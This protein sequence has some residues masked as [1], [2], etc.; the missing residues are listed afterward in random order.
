M[1][2]KRHTFS[3]ED[4]QLMLNEMTKYTDEQVK[5]VLQKILPDTPEAHNN[6]YRGKVLTDEY[7]LND[8]YEMVEARN[9]HDIFVGDKIIV[10]MGKIPKTNYAG[11]TTTFLV[12]EIESHWNYGDDNKLPLNKGHL[13]LI[14][15]NTL[16]VAKMNNNTQDGA[17]EGSEMNRTIMEEVQGVLENA[18][19]NEHILTAKEILTDSIDPNYLS[20]GVPNQK[21]CSDTWAWYEKKCRLMTELEVYGSSCFSSSGYDDAGLS[22]QISL[23]RLNHKAIS[24]RESW[25][26]SSVSYSNS[27]CLVCSLGNVNRDNAAGPSS[28]GVRPRFIIGT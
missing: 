2:D 10:E 25:W 5:E 7:S 16:G 13:L 28:Y 27:F 6:F 24:I 20:K 9:Y 18:F 15:Q 1:N 14:P 22:H 12:A 11:G 26:L 21:G 19:G 8:I 3:Q 17:Y 4:V 23:F